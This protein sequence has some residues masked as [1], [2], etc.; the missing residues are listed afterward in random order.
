[1]KMRLMPTICPA[2]IKD[3]ENVIRQTYH[4]SA[5]MMVELEETKQQVKELYEQADLLSPQAKE[6]R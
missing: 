3:W 2:N 4:E 5:R 6:E 1:M